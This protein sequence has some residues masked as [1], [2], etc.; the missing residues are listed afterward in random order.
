MRVLRGGFKKGGA[1]KA[2]APLRAF[3]MKCK[4]VLL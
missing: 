4:Q 2:Q 3:V 1:E